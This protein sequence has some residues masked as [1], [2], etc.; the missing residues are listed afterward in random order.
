MQ[1]TK[2]FACVVVMY[3][4]ECADSPACRCLQQ[5]KTK[6]LQVVVFDNST[7][8]TENQKF[9]QEQGWTFLG[10]AGN[11]GISKAY[12]A[13][14]AHLLNQ[15]Y[16]GPICLFDDDTHVDENY[17]SALS[18]AISQGCA[19]IFVPFIWA[20]GRLI[21][22]SVCTK[23]YQNQLFA[24]EEAA[25]QCAETLRPMVEQVDVARPLSYGCYKICE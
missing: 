12:N 21:S 7:Q 25:E 10:G 20:Q 11:Q 17:F 22:P 23:R 1:S 13:C 15:N 2:D 18:Q 19:S 16:N 8:P 5:V 4:Q 3:N 24:S 9:C 6:K 14:I